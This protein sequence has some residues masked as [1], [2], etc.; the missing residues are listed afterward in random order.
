[1]ESLAKRKTRSH[2]AGDSGSS[3]ELPPSESPAQILN[4][5]GLYGTPEENSDDFYGPDSSQSQ[6]SHSDIEDP[7]F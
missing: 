6:S 2:V 3:D 1:M 4:K 7:G 5:L